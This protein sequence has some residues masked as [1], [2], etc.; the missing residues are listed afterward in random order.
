MDEY[1]VW[2]LIS[3]LSPFVLL[4]GLAV[5]VFYYRHLSGSFRLLFAYLVIS[6][7]VDLLY[8]YF[9]YYSQLK[10]N[11]FLIPI[12]GF[13]ELALFSRIY[14]R[15]ILKCRSN[16]LLLYIALAL[17]GILLE[18]LFVGRLLHQ[19]SF[20]S[21]GKVVDD[22]AII[23]FCILYYWRVFNGSIPIVKAH[24]YLNVAALVYFSINL[25]LFLP[26][27]FLVNASLSVVM[28]FWVLNLVSIV[29]FYIVLIFLLWQNGKTRKCSR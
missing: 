25:I 11:L 22:A 23:S 21:F 20:Q 12:F 28:A 10:Y 4:V 16:I 29:L 6:I 7:A 13:L 5:G 15:Y 3:L 18:L 8:R 9:G 26:I 27:N 24:S 19:K 1:Q 2:S 14:Y 17:L